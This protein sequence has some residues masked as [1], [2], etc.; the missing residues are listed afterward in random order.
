MAIFRNL[1]VNLRDSLWGDLQG[2]PASSLDLLD[3]AK[4]GLFMF[5]KIG[6]AQKQFVDGRSL[7]C[8]Q[9]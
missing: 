3:L 7:V 6:R 5:R 2:A 9:H 4:N 1:C 8:E